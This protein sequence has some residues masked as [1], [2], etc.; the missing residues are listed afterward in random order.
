MD[1]TG[2]SPQTIGRELGKGLMLRFDNAN[3]QD[4]NIGMVVEGVIQSVDGSYR[5]ISVRL[6]TAEEDGFVR[7]IFRGAREAVIVPD[8]S[9]LKSVREAKPSLGGTQPAARPA[10][11]SPRRE[12]DLNTLSGPELL[13]QL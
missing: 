13:G 2:L 6:D 11:L 12:Q 5:Y 7:N 9:A 8:I 4:T 3:T 1:A 10:S